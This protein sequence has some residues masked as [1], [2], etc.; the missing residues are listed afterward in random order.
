MDKISHMSR[1][2]ASAHIQAGLAEVMEKIFH[3]VRDSELAQK[4]MNKVR[5]YWQTGNPSDDLTPSETS[6][7]YRPDD[8]GEVVPLSNKKRLDVEWSNHAEY[9]SDL[10]D[11][12]PEKVNKAI[13]ERLRGKLPHPDRNKIRMKEPGLGTIVMDYDMMGQPAQADV[14]T[15]WASERE[16]RIASKIVISESI[17]RSFIAMEFPTKDALEKY[18]KNHPKADKSKH[19]VKQTDKKVKQKEEPGK[20][21][22][23]KEEEPSKDK[24]KFVIPQ[25][26]KLKIEIDGDLGNVKK[27]KAKILLGNSM[28]KDHKIGDMDEVGYVAINIKTNEIVPIARADEHQTGYELL[29]HLS[30]KGIIKSDPNDFITLFSGNNYPDYSVRRE[31]MGRYVN[32]VKKWLD[33]G[34]ENY[35][36]IMT[37]GER[38][39]T[40][41]KEFVKSNGKPSGKPTEKEESVGGKLKPHAQESVK[42][43]E[44]TAK[45]GAEVATNPAASKKFLNQAKSLIQHLK[46]SK[47]G[48]DVVDDLLKKAETDIDKEDVDGLQEHLFAFNG[49]KN[50]LHNYLRELKKRG[51]KED[52]YFGDVNT[53]F[54]EFNKLGQI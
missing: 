1:R 5:K 12:E 24:G 16:K 8:Y 19:T 7:I 21:V 18:L 45:S 49:I 23:K 28:G 10:R 11:I 25:H 37:E 29:Y 33:Y 51:V 52:D 30:D 36:V 39:D 22:T 34:G 41:M 15:V 32:A 42:L 9:R 54:E 27:W 46:S 38:I 47:I 6:M 17:V 35:P 48:I 43:F 3:R 14:V 31:D 40:D 20:E 26:S 44:D 53:A 2:V 50:F 13:E 4:M